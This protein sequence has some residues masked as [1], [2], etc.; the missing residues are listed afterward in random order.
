MR[1]NAT[2][3]C[4]ACDVQRALCSRSLRNAL[5]NA[6]LEL[7]DADGA[8]DATRAALEAYERIYPPCQSAAR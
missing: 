1:R 8:A 2:W 3:E 6:C 7:G 4:V 5:F